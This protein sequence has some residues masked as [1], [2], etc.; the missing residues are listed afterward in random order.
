LSFAE[1]PI[2]W[3]GSSLADIRALPEAARERL[4]YALSQVQFGFEPPDYRPMPSVGSGVIEIRVQVGRAFRLLYVAKYPEA[5]YV[6]H[7]FEK[8]TTKTSLADRAVARKR[9]AQIPHR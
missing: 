7:V 6:L 5:I 4:G 9:L 8:K 3:L 1:K 2:V